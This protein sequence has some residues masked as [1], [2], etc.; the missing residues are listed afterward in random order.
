MIIWQNCSVKTTYWVLSHKLAK[1]T[2]SVTKD[3]GK[4]SRCPKFAKSQSKLSKKTERV[5]APFL[6]TNSE[7]TREKR[8]L[9]SLY[10]PMQNSFASHTASEEKRIAH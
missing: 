1:I 6:Q 2:R 8:C 10:I 9:M 3:S 7:A 4:E 5:H